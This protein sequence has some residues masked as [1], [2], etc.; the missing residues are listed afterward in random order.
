[1]RIILQYRRFCGCNYYYQFISTFKD[2]S[3]WESKTVTFLIFVKWVV[4]LIIKWL[5]KN[6]P[7][8]SIH[9]SELC[10]RLNHRAM[11][12]FCWRIQNERNVNNS[13]S[14]LWF[15]FNFKKWQ[16]TPK[17]MHLA[18]YIVEI[19]DNP[20]D[21][22]THTV[23]EFKMLYSAKCFNVTATKWKWRCLIF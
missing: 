19:T 11:A 6:L 22:K 15:L 1:M 21:M 7:L 18:P 14:P 12:R 17:R 9:Q 13:L 20:E 3:V 10:T 5:V 4:K 2:L 16:C 8:M 23:K